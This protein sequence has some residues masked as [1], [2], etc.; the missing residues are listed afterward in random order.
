MPKDQR[1]V[2]TIQIMFPIDTDEEALA[3]KKKIAEVLADNKDAQIRF[4]IVDMPAK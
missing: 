2:C 1:E 4:S 3:V